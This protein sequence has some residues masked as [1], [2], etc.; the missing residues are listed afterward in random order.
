MKLD[1]GNGVLL[2][3]VKI[4]AGSFLM[5][6]DYEITL[7][8]FYLGK[9]LITQKQYQQVMGENPSYFKGDNNPV[10]CVSWHSV[11]KFCEKL[12][13]L[14][15]AQ[16]MLPSET[17]WEYAARAGSNTDYFFGDSDEELGDYA[18]YDENSNEHTHP[19]GEKKPNPWGLYDI[20]GN[21]WEWC[22][23]DWDEDYKKLPKDGTYSNITH[24]NVIQDT[25]DGEGK[26][27]RGGAWSYNFAYS[28]CNYRSSYVADRIC[29]TIGL[30]VLVLL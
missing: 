20:L 24:D 18:W 15:G 26:S 11:V 3:L 28:C 27:L 8:S 1:L 22:G 10:E 6:G 21:V 16:V 5:G 17:Q 4:P 23:D 29:Y 14:T 2:E 7:K 12:S 25:A 30:R 9:Y 13:A 19:V